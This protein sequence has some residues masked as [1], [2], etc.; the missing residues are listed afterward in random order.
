MPPKRRTRNFFKPF[1]LLKFVAMDDAMS[2]SFYLRPFNIALCRLGDLLP[3]AQKLLSRCL[4]EPSKVVEAQI[5]VEKNPDH[6]A[7]GFLRQIKADF[8][9][10][11]FP[12]A[13]VVFS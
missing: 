4:A 12:S 6:T 9:F 13:R 1:E 3:D 8:H 7:A 5:V 11:V 10:V 2:N